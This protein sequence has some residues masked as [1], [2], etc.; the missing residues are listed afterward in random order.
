MKRNTLIFIIL[1]A[2]ISAFGNGAAAQTDQIGFS[3]EITKNGGNT[4]KLTLTA[5]VSG[6][7]MWLGVSLYPPNV[8]NTLEE[9][10]H[11]SFSIKQGVTVKE[12]VVDPEYLNGTFEAAVWLRK[13]EK[14]DC[15]EDDAVCNK[16]GYKLDGMTAY[17]W[18]YLVSP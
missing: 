14:K 6:K 2:L 18:A 4:L 1:L 5:H 7:D 12:I 13:L 9:G 3:Y 17:I 8:T 15:A 16:L 10:K 11:L